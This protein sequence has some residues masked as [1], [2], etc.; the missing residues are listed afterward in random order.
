MHDLDGISIAF[1][2]GITLSSLSWSPVL[3]CLSQTMNFSVNLRVKV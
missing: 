3:A 2:L 1:G